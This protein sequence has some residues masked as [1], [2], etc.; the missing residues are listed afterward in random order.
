MNKIKF[1]YVFKHKKH[2]FKIMFFNLEELESKDIAHI[3]ADYKINGWKLVGRN[4]FT[5]KFDKNKKEIYEKDIIKFQWMTMEWDRF[6][7]KRGE[8][9]MLIHD[10][11]EAFDKDGN[12]RFVDK[13]CEVIGNSFENPELLKNI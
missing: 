13:Y 10:L 3:I 7:E 6:P 12:G 8:S 4:Q 1:R 5:G 2:G 11:E 9:I